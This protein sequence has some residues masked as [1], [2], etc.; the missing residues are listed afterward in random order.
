M[1]KYSRF[2]RRFRKKEEEK[3]MGEKIEKIL[4]S[5]QD[6]ELKYPRD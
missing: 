3:G 5:D 6:P 2:T 4:G 1:F